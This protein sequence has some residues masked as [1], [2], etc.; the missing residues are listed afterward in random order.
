MN[1]FYFKKYK[2]FCSK[3]YYVY[4]YAPR[5]CEQHRY[6]GSKTYT[7][8]IYTNRD[9]QIQNFKS[10]QNLAFY[11][12][13][14]ESLA[15]HN[16]CPASAKSKRLTTLHQLTLMKKWRLLCKHKIDV[17][18][19]PFVFIFLWKLLNKWNARKNVFYLFC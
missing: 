15:D 12:G 17:L 6:T 4:S 19:Y 14:G 18:F 10:P 11:R 8:D 9:I 2:Y 16:H 1:A 3:Q 13:Y 5:S 7:R